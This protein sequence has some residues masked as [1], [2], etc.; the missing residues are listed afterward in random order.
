MVQ[1]RNRAATWSEL[2]LRNAN[3]VGIFL[4]AREH[5]TTQSQ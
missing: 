4:T 3:S 2:C 5:I 1:W